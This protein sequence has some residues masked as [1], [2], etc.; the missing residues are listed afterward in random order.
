MDKY[1]KYII[2]AWSDCC[3]RMFHTYNGK[4]VTTLENCHPGGISKIIIDYN[5]TKV[6]SGGEKGE[7]RVWDL[8]KR[9]LGHALGA[10]SHHMK[11]VNQL[12]INPDKFE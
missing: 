4:L 9:K 1:G 3:I 8:S 2:S 6:I 5:E 12:K 10:M 7:I 11:R